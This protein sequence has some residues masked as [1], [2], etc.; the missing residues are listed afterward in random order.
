MNDDIKKKIEDKAL[1]LCPSCNQLDSYSA[2]Q[3]NG[4]ESIG[5]YG[6]SLASEEAGDKDKEIAELKAWKESAMVVM[7]A[8][9]EIGKALGVKLGESIHDKILPGIEK[10]T[11]LLEKS[12]K[13]NVAEKYYSNG[14][15][16]TDDSIISEMEDQWQQ[17]KTENSL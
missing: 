16:T 4:L 13:L 12:F 5:E 9:Q 7:A 11:R 8:M 6:Y 10:L 2:C 17:F 3:C 15:R 1:D 14:I